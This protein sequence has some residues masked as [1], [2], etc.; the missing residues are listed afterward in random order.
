[1]ETNHSDEE[2]CHSSQ[3][4]YDEVS[5]DWV[6]IAPGRNKRPE[7]FKRERIHSSILPNDCPFCQ[8]ND[9]SK[10]LLVMVNGKMATDK[11][12]PSDWTLVVI[13]NKYPAFCPPANTN[14][15][16]RKM[17]IGPIYH[18]IDAVGFAK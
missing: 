18:L 8:I 4:R 3:L 17:H 5:Q 15:P 10:P 12:L 14:I 16:L 6:V 13:P 11:N 7:A 9:Q 1:M 2:K